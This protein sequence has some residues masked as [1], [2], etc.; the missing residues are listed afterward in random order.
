MMLYYVQL[1]RTVGPNTLTLSTYISE[2][3]VCTLII[4]VANSNSSFYNGWS[5]SQSVS[6]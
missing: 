1:C 6:H 3:T 2:Q 5:L 4:L